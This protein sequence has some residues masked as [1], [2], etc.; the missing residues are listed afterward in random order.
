MVRTD[1]GMK[2]LAD[3]KG[4]KVGAPDEDSITSVIMHATL[5]DALG[6]AVPEMTYVHLQDAV[7]FMIE[8]GMVAS[9]GSASQAVVK[10][11]QDKGGKVI[12]TSKPVPI[13]H[14]LASSKLSESQRAL[15]TAYFTGLEQSAEGK[16][17]LDALNVPGF[18]EFDEA[19]L[20]GIGKW[21]GV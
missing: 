5:R 18:L 17:R 19:A 2:T 7:P 13:K 4:Q 15:L 10:D 8:H 9:G 1:S 12:G 20:V 3:L 21:L 11:W 16:R 6:A 14:L